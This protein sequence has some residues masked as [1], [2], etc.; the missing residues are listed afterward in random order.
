MRSVL[1][2]HTLVFIVEAVI[3]AIAVRAFHE[4]FK[5]VFIEVCRADISVVIHVIIVIH[6]RFTVGNSFFGSLVHQD[7][8]FGKLLAESFLS[9]YPN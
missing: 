2:L 7:I 1:L 8:S 3:G 5:V 9:L 6:T 4:A